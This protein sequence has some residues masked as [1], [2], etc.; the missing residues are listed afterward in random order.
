M[1]A[2]LS[3]DQGWRQNRHG[4]HKGHART[5][6]SDRVSPQLSTHSP[7]TLPA[8]CTGPSA[9]CPTSAGGRPPMRGGMEYPAARRLN[10]SRRCSHDKHD[11]AVAAAPTFVSWAASML[12]NCT[13]RS[14]SAHRILKDQ[15]GYMRSNNAIASL[16]PGRRLDTARVRQTGVLPDGSGTGGASDL[17]SGQELG[18]WR[19]S[20][21]LLQ[22]YLCSAI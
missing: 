1:R 10:C 20:R 3:D 12:E 17:R 16:L 2:R 18:T 7:A 4:H 19:S 6:T 11:A 21:C 22:Q 13:P 15:A 5:P 8:P 14:R 9:R